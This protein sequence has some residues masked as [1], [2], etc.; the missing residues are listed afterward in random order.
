MPSLQDIRTRIAS[1]KNTQK[2]TKAMKMVAAAKL[3]R[4]QDAIVARAPVR[5]SASSEVLGSL[6]RRA[7]RERAPAARR[8]GRAKRVELVLL[9]SDRG[10]GGRLQRQRH[11]ARR[12]A[13]SSTSRRQAT[14]RSRSRRSAARAAT[15]ARAASCTIRKDY[16]GHR[17]RPA[18]RPGRGASPRELDRTHYVDARARRG[19]PALQRVQVGHRRSGHAGRSCCPSCRRKPR[20][21]APDAGALDFLYEPSQ[22]ERARR[23]AAAL[24][25][26]ADLAR[27]ARVAWRPSSAPA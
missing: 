4:A 22:G 1:V 7:E 8:C 2:I 21:Q 14:R 11:P 20:G 6:A 10:L 19:L 18:V 25:R 23:A 17:R 3:R 15:S 26:D 16:A 27:D 13:S 12:S 24:P 5:A 9:T